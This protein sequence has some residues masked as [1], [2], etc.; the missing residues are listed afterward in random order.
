M[1][2]SVKRASPRTSGTEETFPKVLRHSTRTALQKTG[3][4]TPPFALPCSDNDCET[5]T[6]GPTARSGYASAPR[7]RDAV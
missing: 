5:I 7:R 6:K 2:A 1:N 4:R 3:H